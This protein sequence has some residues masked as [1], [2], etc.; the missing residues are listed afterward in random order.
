M[1][2]SLAP[3]TNGEVAVKAWQA[4]SK[5]TGRDHAHLARRARGR[6]ASASATC[7]RSR[8]RSSRRPTWSGLESEHVSYTA[9]Y[10]NVHEL[11]PWRTLTGRQQFYQD[12]KWMRG[13]GEGLCVYRP[14]VDTQD[15]RADARATRGNG[16]PEV[17]LNF[18]TPHQKWGI[19]ST[20]TDN[21][22]MLTLSRGGPIVWLS[23]TDAQKRRH[24]RQRLDRALQRERRDHRARRGVASA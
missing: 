10:T 22:L 23:E 12:H 18:I 7:R 24:R 9:G 17:V 14:P 16:N 13:F 21:L 3:E 2:L 6:Q 20:Y 5:I 11:I 8:A 15:D 4:L 1:I 19:H